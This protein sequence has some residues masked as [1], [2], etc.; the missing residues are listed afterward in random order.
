MQEMTGM[1]RV[2]ADYHMHSISPDARVPMEEMCRAAVERGMREI[3]VTD[4]LELFP[5]DYSG[6]EPAMF[7][8]RYIE[9][10]FAEWQRCNE[11][12]DGKLRVRRAVELGQ[13]GCNPARAAEILSRCRYDY[14]LGSVHKVYGVD[15]AFKHYSE[16][17]NETLTRQNLALLYEMA[18]CGDFDCM[19]HID[20]IKRYAGRQGFH[21]RLI[22]YFDEVE[23]ILKRLVRRDKGLEINTS[24]LRQGL[25]E[26][27]PGLDILKLYRSLG[28][29]IL[30]IGSDAHRACDVAADF[31]AAREL[32]LAAGF[33]KLALYEDRKPSFYSIA[34]Q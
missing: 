27:L 18:D 20:L 2:T 22:D 33:T 10:Y 26:T 34:D 19:G 30:V 3:A 12:F 7:D 15:L 13:P 1:N 6:K 9:R 25:G 14:V 23:A 24:G 8:D 16:G 11:L 31:D 5:P 4:H 17:S 29:K 28:G 21:I 32:A